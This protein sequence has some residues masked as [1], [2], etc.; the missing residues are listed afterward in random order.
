MWV[1]KAK[2]PGT[3]PDALCVDILL[4]DLCFALRGLRLLLRSLCL[5]L[6]VLLLL[7]RFVVIV[8]D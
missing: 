8:E 7:A 6:C 1:Q 2:A 5:L 4:R 3:R